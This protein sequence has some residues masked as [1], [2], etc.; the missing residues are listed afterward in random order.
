MDERPLIWKALT[1]TFSFAVSLMLL[2]GPEDA[3]AQSDWL[4]WGYDQQ[5]TGWNQ[6]ETTLTR[7]N[8]S[9]LGVAPGNSCPVH[10]VFLA[11]GP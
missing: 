4:A 6:S 2:L 7:D 10:L 1:I 11:A 9:H 3:A 5:R 8:V